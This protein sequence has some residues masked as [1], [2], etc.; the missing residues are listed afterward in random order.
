M[1]VPELKSIHWISPPDAGGENVSSILRRYV[2][3]LGWNTNSDNPAIIYCGSE[4]QIEK[5]AEAKE[6]YSVPV[7]MNFWGWM[8]ERFRYQEW[9]DHYTDRV[10]LI[11]KFADIITAPS[12][13]VAQQLFLFGINK[14][15]YIFQPGVDVETAHSS[16]T[17]IKYRYLISV[18]RLV[19]HKH[20]DLVINAIK[21][22]HIAIDYVII[23]KGPEAERLTKLAAECKVSLTIYE[24]LNDEDKF[25]WIRSALCLICA[26]SY[27]GFGM[28]IVEAATLGI[29]VLAYKIPSHDEL[30]E[31]CPEYFRNIDQLSSLISKIHFDDL[32]R[33]KLAKQISLL[34]IKYSAFG[35]A[36]LMSR[37]LAENIS[38][39][40][41]ATLASELKSET[42]SLSQLYDI[43]ANIDKAL[44]SYRLRADISDYRGRLNFLLDNVVG[45]RVL[46]A[47]CSNGIFSVHLAAR[48]LSVCAIDISKNYLANSKQLAERYGLTNFIEF[49]QGDVENLTWE[50]NWFDSVWAGEIIEHFENPSK[51]LS[52][53]IRVLK[54]SGRLIFSVPYKDACEDSM[55]KQIFNSEDDFKKLFSSF[56]NFRVDEVTAK[57]GGNKNWVGYGTKF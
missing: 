32:F 54:P 10:N 50:D 53:L 17:S 55:H 23:G 44:F 47:G 16:T 57:L 2:E 27:E 48:K 8:P 13:I 40:I 26:S 36:T 11:N 20:F 21:K 12:N 31:D 7:I 35:S 28:P 38:L 34:G 49:S 22:T 24:D 9:R 1:K 3:K 45:P 15:M 18:G 41:K 52:E 5:A 51:M 25:N 37:I 33:R 39:H 46:D 4:S 30:F 56:T 42:I 29:P 6:K 19:P 43:E 14:P